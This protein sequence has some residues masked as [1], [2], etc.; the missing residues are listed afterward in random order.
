MKKI[1]VYV[2]IVSVFCISGCQKSA[3]V[4]SDNSSAVEHIVADD[5][6]ASEFDVDSNQSSEDTTTNITS[7]TTTN[8]TSSTT[9]ESDDN[10][11]SSD[12]IN[13]TA[14][15]EKVT[16]V[17]KFSIKTAN[18]EHIKKVYY[19]SQ[20]GNTLQYCLFLPDDYS[21]DQKYPV[22][23]FLHGAGEIGSDNVT[24]LRNINNMFT[25]NSDYVSQSILIC[26]Q[27]P[28]WWR[29]DREYGDGKGTLT[30]ALHLLQEIQNEYS[31]DENRIYLTGLS[32]GG[33][34]TWELLQNYGE[35]FAAAVP[36]C[37]F[38]NEMLAHTLVDIPIRIYH[39]TADPTVSFSSS[40]DMYNAIVAAGGQKVELFPLEGVG[41]D[42]WLY[43]YAD[44]TMFDW[45]F[46]QDKSKT[47]PAIINPAVPFKVV[48]S[49][50]NT[51]ITDDDIKEVDYT[52]H[53]SKNSCPVDIEL[54]L[55]DD[56]K[57]KLEKAYTT[58]GGKEFTVYCR[59]QKIYSFTATQPPIDNLFLISGVFKIDNYLPYYHMIN[60]ACFENS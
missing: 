30:S 49:N 60:D 39:G 34:A 8:V 14:R 54:L 27:T 52:I 11:I 37:G 17:Y 23:L 50:G 41:H 6:T 58:S 59:L 35:I 26:P 47:T 20:N 38:G 13:E 55:T 24:Q 31:C 40:Q 3:S 43:A 42:A 32:M 5:A 57:A 29:L 7:D 2:L 48:D 51:V 10:T 46:A 53:T 9:T 28:E 25:K 18:T 19:D 1:I 44:T 36:V 15:P 33:Y 12:I 16:T 56:G 22:I 4:I 45:M 21:P